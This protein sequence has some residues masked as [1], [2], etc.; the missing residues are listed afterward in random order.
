MS[1]DSTQ[2]RKKPH[3]CAD[4]GGS[5]VKDALDPD[6]EPAVRRLFI[7]QHVRS[8]RACE[9]PVGREPARARLGRCEACGWGFGGVHRH[10]ADGH[11]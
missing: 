2:G 6:L 9:R 5:F 11:L 7:Y 4:L 3:G 8:A 1:P 10:F